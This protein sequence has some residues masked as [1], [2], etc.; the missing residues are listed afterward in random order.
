MISF[1]TPTPQKR[2]VMHFLG[3]ETALSGAQGSFSRRL[4]RSA[5]SGAHGVVPLL[6]GMPKNLSTFFN[7]PREC[8]G[9]SEKWSDG[10]AGKAARSKPAQEP[11]R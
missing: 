9:R 1:K 4:R 3:C 2:A 8:P 5:L 11:P 7:R 10:N 6:Y